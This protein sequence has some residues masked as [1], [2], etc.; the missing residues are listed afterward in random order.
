[1]P[2]R[3]TLA[4]RETVDTRSFTEECN[5][6]ALR[7]GWPGGGLQRAFKTLG[8]L[9]PAKL[10]QKFFAGDMA[11]GLATGDPRQRSARAHNGIE[12]PAGGFAIA[13]FQAIRDEKIHAKMVRQWTKDVFQELA[14]QDDAFAVANRFDQLLSSLA[15]QLR[16]QDIVKVLFAEEVEA[17][18]ADAPKQCVQE[19]RG[20]RA[21]R[22]ISEGP[23]QRHAGHARAA[24]PAFRKTLRVPGEKA[25][26]AQ[27]AKFEQGAFDAPIGNGAGPGG[28][29]DTPRIGLVWRHSRPTTNG[30]QSTARIAQENGD[31]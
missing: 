25:D 10:V 14:N 5:R 11:V 31:E 15:A 21:T 13:K 24:G 20:K 12:E 27:G 18:A 3:E 7:N 23:R 4:D 19:T 1:M 9:R 2:I 6:L 16:L 28:K 17:I 26:R 22:K 30:N 29:Q 8:L